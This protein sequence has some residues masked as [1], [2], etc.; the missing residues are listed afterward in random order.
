MGFWIFRI[1]AHPCHLTANTPLGPLPPAFRQPVLPHSGSLLLTFLTASYMYRSLC[2]F[3]H[4]PQQIACS[5]LN[6][7]A[8]Q[9][10]K[11]QMVFYTV[12]SLQFTAHSSQLTPQLFRFSVDRLTPATELSKHPSEKLIV[13]LIPTL[14]EEF[15]PVVALDQSFQ[16]PVNKTSP[17]NIPSEHETDSP[18][19]NAVFPEN[20][21]PNQVRDQ[22]ACTSRP[23]GVSTS[24]MAPVR[25]SD[26]VLLITAMNRFVHVRSVASPR[27]FPPSSNHLS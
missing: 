21:L 11:Y 3:S 27:P 8:V 15:Y 13:V 16:T 7:V 4:V 26:F 12:H 9:I 1:Q 24:A 23:G 19:S 2:V 25:F 10:T 5:S 18:H 6:F 22:R 20:K 17:S 14:H